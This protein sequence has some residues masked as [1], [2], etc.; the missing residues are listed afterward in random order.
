MSV[1]NYKKATKPEANEYSVYIYHRPSNENNQINSWERKTVTHNLHRA[2]MKAKSLY[3][4]NKYDRVEL[5]RTSFNAQACSKN[6]KIVKIYDEQHCFKHRLFEITL[7]FSKV[8]GSL[9]IIAG[10]F[11]LL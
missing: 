8:L 4:S 2:K 11:A 1:L 10:F 6:S 5:Q 3:E 9:A 7:L